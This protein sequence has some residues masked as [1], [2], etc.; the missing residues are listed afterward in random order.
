MW[1][2]VEFVDKELV[3]VVPVSWLEEEMGM[4]RWPTAKFGLLKLVERQIPPFHDGKNLQWTQQK[5]RIMGKNR[6]KL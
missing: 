3:E 2:V 5:K 1:T 4:C 6:C